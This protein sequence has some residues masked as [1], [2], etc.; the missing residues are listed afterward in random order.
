MKLII[1]SLR[2]ILFAMPIVVGLA[3]KCNGQKPSQVIDTSEYFTFKSSYWINLHHFLYQQAQG[4]QVKKAIE[5]GN[6]LLEIGDDSIRQSLLE[7]ES[8]RLTKAIEYYKKHLISKSLF[9]LS[10][11]RVWLEN[12]M[13]DGIIQD[14]SYTSEYSQIL[15]EF[16]SIYKKHFWPTHNAHNEKVLKKHFETIQQIEKKAVLRLEQL[17]GSTWPKGKVRIE[18][19]TYADYAGGYTTTYPD[20]VIFIS[21]LDPLA[22]ESDF[23]ETVF[24]EGSHLLFTMEGIFRSKIF[25]KSQESKIE[26]PKELWHASQFY[27]CGVLIKDLLNPLGINHTLTMDAKKIYSKYNTPIFRKIL[28]EYYSHKTD[29]DS[30]VNGLLINMK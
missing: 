16:S 26:F 7:I 27:L 22:F 23:I 25:F 1:K 28:D 4:S 14:T 29:L 18:L 12:Q 21:T 2:N 24:H 19:T 3:N 15:N 9:K 11:M 5:D 13:I 20:M 10:N 17:S 30:T 8:K 6:R